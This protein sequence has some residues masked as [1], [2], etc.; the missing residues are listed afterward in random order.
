MCR[1]SQ[2]ERIG[3][4]FTGALRRRR[5]AGTDAGREKPQER[6]GE[7]SERDISG[8]VLLCLAFAVLLYLVLVPT[9]ASL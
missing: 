1:V 3:A 4:A 6:G 5:V 9:A 2:Y 8:T 7:M